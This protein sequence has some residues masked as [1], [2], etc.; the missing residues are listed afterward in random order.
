[1]GS[2]D[3]ISLTAAKNHVSEGANAT[4]YSKNTAII[5]SQNKQCSQ[6]YDKA[7]AT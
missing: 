6:S 1:M 4:V 3:K 5:Y 7:A 2:V